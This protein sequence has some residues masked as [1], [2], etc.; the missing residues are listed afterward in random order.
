MEHSP[1]SHFQL[2]SNQLKLIALVAMTCDHV[3]IILL[4]QVTFLRIIGRLAFPIFSFM[5]AEG[6]RYTSNRARYL[7][8]VFGVG[9]L[10]QTIYYLIEKSVYQCILITFSLSIGLI[11]TILWARRKGKWR[12]VVCAVAFLFVLFL[13]EGLPWRLEGTDF[14]IDYG[15][16]GVLLPVL[17]YC[18]DRWWEKLAASA[19]GLILLSMQFGDIEWYSLFAL[20]L[21]AC[22]RGNRGERKLKYFFYIYYPLHLV[23]IWSIS[24]LGNR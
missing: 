20:V 8:T 15:F 17:I 23:A 3:G 11:Y 24:L 22:Y 18:V 10:W 14:N 4:P 2:T 19:F 7:L 12:W 5:I 6:C 9:I 21:L 13:C 1:A 16:T